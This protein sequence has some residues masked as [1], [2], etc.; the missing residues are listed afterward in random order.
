MDARRDP[1]RA[2]HSPPWPGASRLSLGS[3]LLGQ[4]RGALRA[5]PAPVPVHRGG[6]GHVVAR[7][8]ASRSAPAVRRMTSVPQRT[9]LT[10]LAAPSH[11]SS[12][13]G[14]ARAMRYLDV[15]L[16]ALTTVSAPLWYVLWVVDG[17]PRV[18]RRIAELPSSRS[19]ERWSRTRSRSRA[20]RPRMP[21]SPGVRS[22]LQSAT[23]RRPPLDAVRPSR[24]PACQ[25]ADR[26]S[27]HTNSR[28]SVASEAGGYDPPSPLM[29]VAIPRMR[30]LARSSPRTRSFPL[31]R[32]CH[33]PR[34]THPASW[35]RTGYRSRYQCRSRCSGR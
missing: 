14:G 4:H 31:V 19:W 18:R 35:S 21:G 20:P 30:R 32:R 10:T 7:V 22:A 24:C 34:R 2:R 8:Y 15:G 23:L 16:I 13:A 11:R 33:S 9:F 25:D 3:S 6:P 28:A 26:R 29:T 12:R 5:R 17:P 1:R 27:S